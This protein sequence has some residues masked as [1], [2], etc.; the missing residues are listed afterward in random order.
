M[1][2]EFSRYRALAVSDDGKESL[3]Y[4]GVN[5]A[6]VRDNYA[7]PWHELFDP[8]AQQEVTKISLQ[9]WFGSPNFGRW[10]DQDILT[11]PKSRQ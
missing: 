2:H 10:V 6:H 7:S 1:K 3:I 4:L 9:K 5:T 11:I 8:E